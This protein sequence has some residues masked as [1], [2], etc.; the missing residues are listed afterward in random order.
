[1]WS[2]CHH[3]QSIV[4]SS[5]EHKPSEW[6]MD[7]SVRIVVFIGS[8]CRVINEIMYELWWRTVYAPTR[9]LFWCLFPSLLRKHHINPAE[10]IKQFATRVH[11]P[12][13][14]HGLSWIWP[15][16]KSIS[17]ELD[18]TFHVLA[19]Q[20]SDHVI[21]LWRHQQNEWVHEQFTTPVHILSSI[22]PCPWDT[23]KVLMWTTY[24]VLGTANHTLADF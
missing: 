18:I 16:M 14:V 11:I 12:Y 2:L 22:Y 1:M 15:W 9:V 3:Q 10:H 17:N 6:D 4:T 5:A 8:L 7:R 23:S 13:F 20:L 21:V 19:W 24:F